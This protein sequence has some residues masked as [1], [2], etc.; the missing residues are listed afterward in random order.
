MFHSSVLIREGKIL[1][2]ERVE[3][4]DKNYENRR[5][6]FYEKCEK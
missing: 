1:D 3:E 6:K 2:P 4:M 5:V